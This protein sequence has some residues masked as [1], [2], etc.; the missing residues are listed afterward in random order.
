MKRTE[1][2]KK[3]QRINR[4]AY[5]LAD[6]ALE[7]YTFTPEQDEALDAAVER[8]ALYALEA[9][10]A[11]SVRLAQSFGELCIAATEEVVRITEAARIADQNPGDSLNLHV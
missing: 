11:P 7:S 2:M 3:L 4:G 1:Y 5:R 8:V 9:R 6:A 10:T